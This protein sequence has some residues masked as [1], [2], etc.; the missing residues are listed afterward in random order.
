MKNIFEMDKSD[1]KADI[2]NRLAKNRSSNPEGF[3]GS[4]FLFSC[5]SPVV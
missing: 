2:D 3:L 1:D 5:L 4:P